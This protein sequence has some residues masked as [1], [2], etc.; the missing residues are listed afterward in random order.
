MEWGSWITVGF[1]FVGAY[2]GACVV[3]GWCCNKLKGW[4]SMW[5][6]KNRVIKMLKHQGDWY[7]EKYKEAQEINRKL[8]EFN[9]QTETNFKNTLVE[10][11]TCGCA[12]FKGSAVKGKAEVKTKKIEKTFPWIPVKYETDEEYIHHPYYC[13]AHDPNKVKEPLCGKTKKAG[14]K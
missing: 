4:H 5:G 14:N 13:K 10:C 11:E 3:V 9:T 2:V 12:V 8:R 1:A 6:K 7:M